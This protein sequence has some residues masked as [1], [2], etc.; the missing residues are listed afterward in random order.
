M[1]ESIYA[2]P[3]SRERFG[4]CW[5]RDII[6]EYLAH[7]NSHGYSQGTSRNKG[8]VLLR[9]AE[10]VEAHGRQTTRDL[11]DWVRPFLASCPPPQ[12]VG[13][14]GTLSLFLRYLRDKGVLPEE[15]PFPPDCPF[16]KTLIEYANYL[17]E[18]RNYSDAHT[19]QIRKH[20]QCFF[21]YVH[22]SGTGRL[23]NMTPDLI[24]RFLVTDA[25]GYSRK[26]ISKRCEILRALLSYLHSTGKTR[27]DLSSIVVGP[28]I[29]RNESCPRFLTR[30]EVKSV[31]GAVD[32]STGVG[33]RDYAILLLLS[34]Y[35]LRGI[36]ARRLCLEDIAWREDKIFIRGRKAGNHCAYPLSEHVGQAILSY[37]HSSRPK[38][39]YRQVFLSH[40]APHAP[41]TG[42]GLME[43]L[44]KHIRLAGLEG[45]PFGTHTLRYSCAQ[46]LLEG[47]FPLKA[48]GD[49]LGHRRLGS[50]RGYLKIDIPH[51]REV[52]RN[53][54]EDLL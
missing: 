27:Q 30:Q 47:D 26:T 45:K 34:T 51:L 5:L 36:E 40:L 41:L 37:L 43:V 54:G 22:D 39:G 17:D 44:R 38:N 18:H 4:R 13:V 50:T 21:R 12:Y 33:K 20:C 53:S 48:I 23:R 49:Y 14:K 29:Y 7:L 31:L 46:Y 10:F 52:A 19:D 32:Q 16:R 9:F 11:A 2:S 35:G 3:K 42:S 25:Q 1:L 6:D 28:R 8:Y 15:G 24:Q